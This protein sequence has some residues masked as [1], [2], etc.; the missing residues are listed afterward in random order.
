L[1]ED[2]QDIPTAVQEML[3]RTYADGFLLLHN[4]NIL[5]EQ[6]FNGMDAST[7]HLIM[8]CSKSITSAV[9]GVYIDSGT[10]DP[11]ALITDYLP[12]LS[13]SGLAGATVQNALDMQVGT[14]FDEN[15]EDLNADWARY[16][17]ATGWRDDATYTGPRNQMDFAA[18]MRSRGVNHGSEF[19]YQSALTNIFGCC[20]QRASGKGFE[21]LLVE[22][23][24]QPM[25]AEQ[26]F[27][28]VMDANDT[29]SFEGGFNVCLRDFARFGQL[30]ARDGM[31]EGQQLLP[32]NWLREC[33]FPQQS[34][35]DEFVAA[36]YGDDV[37]SILATGTDAKVTGVYHNFW[38]VRDPLQGVALAIGI[39]GQL[40]YVDSQ[41]DI[42]VAI[43]SSE[44]EHDKAE[45][46]RLRIRAIEA[47][48]AKLV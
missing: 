1:G 20:L 33:R 16:E 40:L 48:K 19:Q 4:G 24:W 23:I 30:I 35:I 9:A 46:W 18:T 3:T 8:S 11:S 10:L 34:F 2:H 6:Y 15:Y 47:I 17:V 37:T 42:V 28:A 45:S 36:D 13:N 12:E 21:Q 29:M 25:G 41:N 38:W 7:S 39:H 22:H 44:P 14:A 26:D 43:L 31:H 32:K 27:F 5:A